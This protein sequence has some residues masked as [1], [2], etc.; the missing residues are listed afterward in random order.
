MPVPTDMDASGARM[1]QLRLGKGKWVHPTDAQ[2]HG[3]ASA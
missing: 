1:T 2:M 3:R